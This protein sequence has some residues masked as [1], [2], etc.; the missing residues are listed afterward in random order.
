MSIPS[1]RTIKKCI[2]ELRVLIDIS[3]DPAVT[4]IAYGMEC[5][6]RWVIEDTVGWETPA[7]TVKDLAAA[8]HNELKP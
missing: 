3:K 5:A 8:L 1:Q 6:L 7:Q 4:K 2:K